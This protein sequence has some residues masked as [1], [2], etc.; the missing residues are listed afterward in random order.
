M[1]TTKDISPT[2]FNLMGNGDIKCKFHHDSDI[3]VFG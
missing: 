2:G 1:K 3:N